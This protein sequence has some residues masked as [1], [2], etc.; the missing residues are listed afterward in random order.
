MLANHYSLQADC[1]D[2]QLFFLPNKN[3]LDTSVSE[4]EIRHLDLKAKHKAKILRSI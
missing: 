1:H 2:C 3:N 4:L